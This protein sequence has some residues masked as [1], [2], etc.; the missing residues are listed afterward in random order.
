MRLLT[1]QE[2][3]VA[4]D[5]S[6]AQSKTEAAMCVNC[7]ISG[8]VDHYGLV[9]DGRLGVGVDLRG[10]SHLLPITSSLLHFSN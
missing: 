10:N 8:G 1:Q 4:S 2:A 7:S 9:Y 5:R 3:D 6:P